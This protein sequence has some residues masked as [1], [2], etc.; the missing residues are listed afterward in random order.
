[1]ASTTSHADARNVEL[2]FLKRATS[3]AEAGPG[4]S[5]FNETPENV[6][7]N[8]DADAQDASSS[9]TD[10][11]NHAVEKER[12]GTPP[13]QQRSKAQIAIIMS[14][15]GV[16]CS[17]AA[18]MGRTLTACRWPCSS[19]Q[20]MSYVDPSYSFRI[21]RANSDTTDHHHHRRPHH[22]RA[23][24]FRCWIHL[25]RLSI[26]ARQLSLDSDMGQ[27]I[28]YLGSQ[29]HLADCELHVLHRLAHRR[30]VDEY[31]YAD[32]CPSYTRYW[33]RR[34]GCF[35]Q[36]L[37]QRPVQSQVCGGHPRCAVGVLDWS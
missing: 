32:R 21:P 24:P 11:Q 16:R 30:A 13:E 26:L 23:F 4:A 25:D 27:D 37:Y 20:W 19:Q 17:L 35:G 1:M 9:S 14:A 31:R 8:R 28:R 29:A 3:E 33:W 18:M 7:V 12:P 34:S 15:L 2:D 10:S 36:H 22:L 5:G 6:V